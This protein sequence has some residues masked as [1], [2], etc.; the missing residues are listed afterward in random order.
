M[1]AA[2]TT[3]TT[4][5]RVLC[6][7][8]IR[9]F[10]RTRVVVPGDRFR[11]G[12]GLDR[13]GLAIHRPQDVTTT[14]TTTTT[15]SRAQPIHFLKRCYSLS[16]T[17]YCC[18]HTLN[19]PKPPR[20][21]HKQPQSKTVIRR[22]NSEDM[23]PKGGSSSSSIQEGATASGIDFGHLSNYFPEASLWYVLAGITLT[24]VG[25]QHLIGELWEQLATRVVHH[26]TS[27]RSDG[28]G[29]VES[30]KKAGIRLR[31]GL[32]KMS[33]LLG[34]PRVCPSLATVRGRSQA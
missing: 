34:Y 27:Q 30:L 18:Y 2:T 16:G 13:R 1:A 29:G 14:T 8:A 20:N 22:V 5:S 19:K 25:R 6:S 24:A 26:E 9:C 23:A 15:T 11:Q 12:T 28:V 3:A 21:Q 31:E 33:V 32:M 4:T 7:G 10:M 17:R